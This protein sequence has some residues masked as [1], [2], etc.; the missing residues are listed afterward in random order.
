MRACLEGFRRLL[1]RKEDTLHTNLQYPSC[2]GPT[3]RDYIQMDLVNSSL[4]ILSN[5]FRLQTMRRFSMRTHLSHDLHHFTNMCLPHG[6][7]CSIK[8][9]FILDSSFPCSAWLC[10]HTHVH[11]TS[12]LPPPCGCIMLLISTMPALNCISRFNT[13]MYI[14]YDS[15]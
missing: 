15:I 11:H 12:I 10:C 5:H 1:R 14:Q 9:N 3:L 6:K 7:P 8:L 13:N 2:Y 4:F